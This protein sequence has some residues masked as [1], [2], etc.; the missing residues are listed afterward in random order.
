MMSTVRNLSFI[1]MI[2]FLLY[3]GE[4]LSSSSDPCWMCSPSINKLALSLQKKVKGSSLNLKNLSFMVTVVDGS[5]SKTFFSINSEIKRNPASLS[6][7]L[8]ATASL[9]YWGGRKKEAP[10][11]TSLWT[12]GPIENGKL[13]GDLYLKGGG[14]PSFT[15]ESLWKLIGQLK[16]YNIHILEGHIAIDDFLFDRKYFER[17][18]FPK[19]SS[20]AYDAPTNAASL[21]WNTFTVLVEPAEKVNQPCKVFKE[22]DTPFLR[23]VNKTKTEVK[24]TK[25]S[26]KLLVIRR[27]L[28]P[29]GH[30]V[31]V[32]GSCYLGKKRTSFYRSVTDPVS[33]MGSFVKQ[34]LTEKNIR[35]LKNKIL[36]KKTPSQARFLT[37]EKSKPIT[38]LIDDLMKYSNNNI[39]ESLAKSLSLGNSLEGNLKEGVKKIQKILKDTIDPKTYVL[40]N[41]SGYTYKNRISVQ[42][43]Q[44]LVLKLYKQSPYSIE[45]L[46]SLPVSGRN[47]TL[48][49]RLEK[50]PG[51]IRAK[52]GLLR[53]VTGLS[54]IL[55][56]KNQNIHFIF[57]FIYNGVNKKVIDANQLFD[58]LLVHLSHAKL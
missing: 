37:S 31:I 27:P 1:F 4:G 10:F 3:V 58:E 30:K 6:K 26:K 17:S 20:R 12:T 55:S 15:Q 29:Y 16:Y 24:K 48:K 52:T 25:N 7:I 8:T 34:F 22:F 21:S 33:W 45:Y 35:F 53:G 39:A 57:T 19:R 50:L 11:E 23:I 49:K 46:F 43:I 36:H 51:Q 13:K 47:G 40:K 38:F 9:R 5:R 44:S 54:G 56:P 18:R 42:T 28:N 2:S 41:P 32:E 14:D